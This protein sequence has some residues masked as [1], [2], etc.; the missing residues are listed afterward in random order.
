MLNV[1]SSHLT[2]LRHARLWIVAAQTDLTPTPLLAVSACGARG[3]AGD[4]PDM[5]E[6]AAGIPGWEG[7][8]QRRRAV[9]LDAALT[10][11][12]GPGELA[13]VPFDEGFGF[14]G[15][16]EVLV[17]AGVSLADLGVS[18]LDE[19][20]IAF[21][22]RP[23]GE[24]EADD[25]ASIREPVSA[26]RVAHRPQ[27]HKGVEVLGGD[28]EPTRTPLAE[29]LADREEVVARGREL[30]VVPA[31]VGLGCRHDDTESFELLEPL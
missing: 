28:L 6:H 5:R 30:V 25:D 7:S 3:G 24:V 18:E 9:E 29:R 2:R 23:A 12:L 26:Q 31:S 14:R 19:Q 17:E 8:Y 21:T 27:R 11:G 20:P 16:V 10:G 4:R 15:D 22:A 13:C 1:S